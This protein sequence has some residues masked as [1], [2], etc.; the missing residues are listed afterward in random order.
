MLSE[1][2]ARKVVISR[3]SI[4]SCEANVTLKRLLRLKSPVVAMK[5]SSVDIVHILLFSGSYGFNLSNKINLYLVHQK[6][7]N[8]IH[9]DFNFNHQSITHVYIY[10]FGTIARKSSNQ[11]LCLLWTHNFEVTFTCSIITFGTSNQYHWKTFSAVEL[12]WI[13]DIDSLSGRL[14]IWPKMSLMLL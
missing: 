14:W 4:I 11:P 8:V 3:S 2:T 13:L 6:I 5:T 12:H 1:V 9:L 7:V 10:I